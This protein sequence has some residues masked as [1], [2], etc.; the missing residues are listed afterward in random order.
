MAVILSPR[1]NEASNMMK[2]FVRYEEAAQYFGIAQEYLH[3]H[4]DHQQAG[5]YFSNPHF[6]S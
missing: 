5:C 2:R 1:G 6:Y 4:P 3:S